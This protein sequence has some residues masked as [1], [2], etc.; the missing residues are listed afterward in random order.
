MEHRRSGAH[1]GHRLGGLQ[2]EPALGT[3]TPHGT[4]AVRLIE[5]LVTPR[6]RGGQRP[7][8]ERSQPVPPV[9]NPN[10]SSSRSSSCPTPS[11]STRAA[12]SSIASGIPSSRVTSRATAGPVPYRVRSAYRRSAPGRRT[13]RLPPTPPRPPRSPGPGRVSG[14][15]RYPRLPGHPPAAPGWSP[16]P[17]HHHRQTTALR[18]TPAAAPITCSQLSSTSS[19]C[20]RT[21][22]RAIAPAAGR[23]T[24]GW[25]RTPS[26]AAVTGATSAGSRTDASSTST[27]VGEPVRHPPGHLTDASRV[28]PAPPW[29]GHRHQPVLTQQ[30]RD[31]A[32]RFRPADEARQRRREAVYA[33][34][35]GSRRSAPRRYHNRAL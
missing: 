18:T 17:A 34:R 28:L 10:R 14:A 29:T 13:A 25:S 8:P 9:S 33:T 20:C 1:P 19:S 30:A 11:A 7:L 27:P 24:P 35:L 2:R 26:A 32:H 3:P 23:P 15:S 21:S 16:A 31:L 4:P 12:A 5:Q 22:T 6:H